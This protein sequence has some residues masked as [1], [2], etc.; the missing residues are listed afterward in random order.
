M[1]SDFNTVQELVLEEFKNCVPDRAVISKSAKVDD[2]A[3][4]LAK[5][6]ALTN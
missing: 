1:A 2:P 5:E 6:L 3:R 4:V